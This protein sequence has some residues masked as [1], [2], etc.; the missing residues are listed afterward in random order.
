M[1]IDYPVIDESRLKLLGFLEKYLPGV[2]AFF[3]IASIISIIHII[4][5]V[6]KREFEFNH[7]TKVEISVIA[8]TSYMISGSIISLPIVVGFFYIIYFFFEK[9]LLKKSEQLS[10]G[11]TSVEQATNPNYQEARTEV[12]T[13]QSIESQ[14]P[15]SEKEAVHEILDVQDAQ[16]HLDAAVGGII[17]QGLLT[18][19]AIQEDVDW[20]KQLD[21]E[22]NY[23]TSIEQQLG[24][25]QT[26]EQLEQ[27]GKSILLQVTQ[28]LI[29]VFQ[30]IGQELNSHEKKIES[31]LNKE[32]LLFKEEE[33][34]LDKTSELLK[35]DFSRIYHLGSTGKNLLKN[36]TSLINAKN[37][38]I[39]KLAKDEKNA[40]LIATLQ[41]EIAQ[42]KD[43]YKIISEQQS[44]LQSK[45]AETVKTLREA[46]MQAS[47][48]KGQFTNLRQQETKVIE[49]HLNLEKEAESIQSSTEQSAKRLSD[50]KEGISTTIIVEQEKTIGT[51]MVHVEKVSETEE[52]TWAELL[53]M[54]GT[55]IISLEGMS[56]LQQLLSKTEV[57]FTD[58]IASLEVIQKGEVLLGG[59][60]GAKISS[61]NKNN[62]EYVTALKNITGRANSIHLEQIKR[63]IS[64]IQEAKQKLE[65]HVST[66]MPKQRDMLK[67]KDE[68]LRALIL[69]VARVYERK[70]AEMAQKLGQQAQQANQG[71]T[72]AA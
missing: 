19:Q 7:L 42:L 8:I 71:M 25:A 66:N 55:Q 43:V 50:A 61:D 58:A 15:Q 32:L 28:Q 3:T 20:E 2:T 57:L 10:R 44:V 52:K 18:E 36:I 47:T 51:V 4:H 54:H 16:M 11:E 37:G 6:R 26:L 9:W 22:L 45:I 38:E 35:Y 63:A 34:A 21:A 41:G 30:Q 39:K 40:P 53:N 5:K 69:R 46:Q 67:R 48:T 56:A 68:S 70:T 72:R 33:N 24:G 13:V 60:S 23:L 59:F 31:L 14:V 1:P 27:Q 17:E 12:T 64:T 65:Q 49:S 62:S 29:K